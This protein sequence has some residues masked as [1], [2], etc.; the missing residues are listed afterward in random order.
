[1]TGAHHDICPLPN[2]NVLVIIHDSKTAAKVTAAGGTFSG[3]VSSEKIQELHPTGLTTDVVVWE[4]KLW[5]HL[6]QSANAG[7]TQLM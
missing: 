5:D 1:L 7:I 6:C 4:W 2:E 3:A